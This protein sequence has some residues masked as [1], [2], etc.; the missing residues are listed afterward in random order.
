MLMETL[1]RDTPLVVRVFEAVLRP[2]VEAEWAVLEEQV[3]AGAMQ[4]PGIRSLTSGRSVSGNRTRV[5]AVT[6]WE[7]EALRSLTGHRLDRPGLT[8]A[9]EALVESWSLHL[10]EASRLLLSRQWTAGGATVDDDGAAGATT[11][12]TAMDRPSSA[13]PRDTE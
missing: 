1:D 13:V 7:P 2:G 9:M 11:P 8:P 4:L 3:Y 12:G 6:V 10:Y 5:V